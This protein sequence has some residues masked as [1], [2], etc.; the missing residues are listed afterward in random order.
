MFSTDLEV[1]Q[2]CAT[3]LQTGQTARLF[4]VVET[5]G[6]SP[7]P[8][9]A[10][11]AINSNGEMVGSVS[12]GCVEADL[13]E[14]AL[15]KQLNH[16][17]VLS[18]GVTSEQGARFGLPCGGVLRVVHEPL[19]DLTTIT[20][21]IDALQQRQQL[22]KQL[23]VDNGAVTFFP[24]TNQDGVTFDGKVLTQVFGPAWQLLIIGAAQASRYLAEFAQALDYHVVICD[25]RSEYNQYWTLE[26]TKLDTGMPDDVVNAYIHDPR[27]AVVALTHDP[28]LDDMAL[29][30]ALESPAFY[31][32]ALGSRGNSAA[33]R[34]RLQ[35]LGISQIAIDR[36]HAPVGL[37]IGSRTPPEIAIAILAEMTAIRRG[38]KSK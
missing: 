10:L 35:Q 11:L 5:W 38:V 3:W 28:K 15:T 25:P 33:R 8:L 12:G 26:G 27:S 22:G 23:Q 13:R 18:Y 34:K 29:L 32:G 31:V 17:C 7:R 6:S 14:Q 36:L 24:I 19:A 37:D 9:G 21:L 1:L 2:R 4:T 20:P 16:V 30:S